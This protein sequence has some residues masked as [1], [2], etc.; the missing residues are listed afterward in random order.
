MAASSSGMLFRL[1]VIG[2][3]N[4]QLYL[5]EKKRLAT[6]FPKISTDSQMV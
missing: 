2:V 6:V 4:F 3:V 5:S 1:H